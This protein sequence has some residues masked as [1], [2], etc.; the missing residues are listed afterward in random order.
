[1]ADFHCAY[2][3]KYG[4]GK[5]GSGPATGVSRP[6]GWLQNKSWGFGIK[7][8]CSKKCKLADEGV[9]EN[10]SQSDAKGANQSHVKTEATK[11]QGPNMF[12][13]MIAEDDKKR[14]REQERLEEKLNKIANI[15]FGNN[16]DEI[17][18]V[19]NQLLALV[20][21]NKSNIDVRKV[22]VQKMEF[23]ILKLKQLGSTD[24]EY[25]QEKLMKIKP[26]WWEI[27]WNYIK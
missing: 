4:Y 18:E 7:Y 8:Y 20:A 25:F 15:Q 17:S 24:V 12:E 6:D 3:G 19:L 16:L 14:E 5:P 22:V 26:K 2:C 11:P 13:R 10:S 9:S 23:G 1:M 27:V 21:S